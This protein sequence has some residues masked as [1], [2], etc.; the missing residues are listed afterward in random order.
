MQKCRESTGS[1]EK[2]AGGVQESAHSERKLAFLQEN[3]RYEEKSGLQDIPG[4][5]VRG[6]G[7]LSRVFGAEHPDPARFDRTVAWLVGEPAGQ[8]QAWSAK[9]NFAPTSRGPGGL[10]CPGEPQ[11]RASVHSVPPRRMNRRCGDA[12]NSDGNA[13]LSS[14]N[15]GRTALSDENSLPPAVSAAASSSSSVLSPCPRAGGDQ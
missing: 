7:V 1:W 15:C 2:R 13:C 3:R 6:H 9:L 11:S 10:E 12:G 5:G 8:S 14:R 4:A